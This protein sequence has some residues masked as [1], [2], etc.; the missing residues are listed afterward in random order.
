MCGM[1]A[2][3]YQNQDTADHD[4]QANYLAEGFKNAT[5][6]ATD[7]D[8]ICANE[9]LMANVQACSLRACTIPQLKDFGRPS[10]LTLS[11]LA[12]QTDF[13]SSE[14][15]NGYPLPLPLAGPGQD[16][17]ICVRSSHLGVRRRV[18]MEVES[19]G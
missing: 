8:C 10:M 3:Q 12:G 6:T 11:I 4:R 2:V 17:L 14:S 1:E 7:A 5:C 9:T 16:G 18:S 13:L 19:A 15:R